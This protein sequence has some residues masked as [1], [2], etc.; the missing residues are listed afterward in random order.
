MSSGV[1][2]KFTLVFP[3]PFLTT[4]QFTVLRPR[5]KLLIFSHSQAPFIETISLT[6]SSLTKTG[7]SIT[8]L[9]ASDGLGFRLCWVATVG[10]YLQLFNFAMTQDQF[11]DTTGVPTRYRLPFDSSQVTFDTGTENVLVTTLISSFSRN[12]ISDPAVQYRRKAALAVAPAIVGGKL[13]YH[14]DLAKTALFGTASSFLF[15]TSP[16]LLNFAVSAIDPTSLAFTLLLVRKPAMGE[17]TYMSMAYDVQTV[18]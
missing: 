7:V 8:V 2:N 16:N 6:F 10:Q 12:Y 17:A 4:P 18:T 13:V 3:A 14:L 11:T 1:S 9:T 15:Q 5:W